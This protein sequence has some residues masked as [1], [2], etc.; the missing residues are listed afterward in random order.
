MYKRRSPCLVSRS[1]KKEGHFSN[2]HRQPLRYH[3]LFVPLIYR[4][5][6]QSFAMRST[7]IFAATASL[8]SLVHA[9]IGGIGIPSTIKP[10]DTFDLI[11]EGQ[12]YIQSVTDVFIAV[13]YALGAAPGDDGLGIFV[14]A[15]DLGELQGLLRNGFLSRYLGMCHTC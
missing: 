6:L 2:P 4:S 10:G 1:L 12:G 3:L 14:A 8:L 5:L 9:R 7:H 13:G 15:F 11:I